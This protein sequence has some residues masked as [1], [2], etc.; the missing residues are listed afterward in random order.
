M[1]SIFSGTIL[2]TFLLGEPLLEPLKNTESLILATIIWYLIFYSPLD[3]AYLLSKTLPCRLIFASL[4]E[5][6]RCHKVLDG[7]NAAAKV[8]PQSYLAM[9]L[10]GMIRGNG[11]AFMKPIV[12]ILRGAW[13]P[14]V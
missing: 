2:A 7:V 13:T 4:K 11:S 14:S 6:G 5:M 3:I 1:V 8:Y 9:A 10:I 12:R